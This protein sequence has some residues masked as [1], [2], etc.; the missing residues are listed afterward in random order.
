MHE[1]SMADAILDTIEQLRLRAGAQKVRKA[2]FQVS[3]LSSLSSE[4]LQMMIDHAA[5]EMGMETFAV[6]V[7]SEGLLGHCPSCGVVVLAEDLSCSRCGM[8]G[9]M[10]AADEAVLVISCEFD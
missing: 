6:E 3:E 4:S 5:E 1:H 2:V 8:P 9:I 10:P 7:I